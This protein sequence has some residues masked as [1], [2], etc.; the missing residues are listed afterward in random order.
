[1]GTAELDAVKKAAEDETSDLASSLAG[2]V[3]ELTASQAEVTSLQVFLLVTPLSCALT[4][5]AR[6]HVKIANA[7]YICRRST[8][9]RDRRALISSNRVCSEP[10][11]PED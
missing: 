2:T 3:A 11:Q 10:R 9:S 6:L 7:W 1:V 5:I 8:Q 4:C